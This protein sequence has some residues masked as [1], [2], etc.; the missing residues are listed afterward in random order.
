MTTRRV[1]LRRK[2]SPL[3]E[4]FLF[5]TFEGIILCIDFILEVF[6]V[7]EVGENEY[8]DPVYFDVYLVLLLAY[9][10]S[11]ILY[12]W[13]FIVADSPSSRAKVPWA[14]L[15]AAIVNTL[16]VIW[17]VV[18]IM[19]IYKRDKVYVSSGKASDDDSGWYQDEERGDKKKKMKYVK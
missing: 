15:I 7:A 5:F 18:Y 6:D 3:D 17:I 1:R 11:V 8:F 4:S 2:V 14:I 12:L 9:A 19:L 13:Y 16:I 10:A